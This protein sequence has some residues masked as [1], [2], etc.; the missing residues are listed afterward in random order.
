MQYSGLV[1]SSL[2]LNPVL[3]VAALRGPQFI[4]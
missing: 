3:K 1:T 4:S 2:S